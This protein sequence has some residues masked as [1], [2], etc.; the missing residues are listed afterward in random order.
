MISTCLRLLGFPEPAGPARCVGP[1]GIASTARRDEAISTFV[2]SERSSAYDSVRFLMMRMLFERP[3]LLQ[4]ITEAFLGAAL[5]L[6]VA[7]TR[8]RS[9]KNYNLI[10]SLM[11]GCSQRSREHCTIARESKSPI[12]R[13]DIKSASI[14]DYWKLDTIS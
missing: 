9:S 6:C 14:E 3:G 12:W 10:F 5:A 11:F 13:T 7:A 1:F 4:P 8:F 2:R